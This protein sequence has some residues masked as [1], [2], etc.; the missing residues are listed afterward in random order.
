MPTYSPPGVYVEETG[1]RAKAIEGVPTSVT[2]FVGPTLAVPVKRGEHPRLTSF[3]E[4][5]AIYG[6]LDDLMLGGGGSAPN[7]LAY[8]ARAFF[9]GGG[10]R[11]YVATTP[12]GGSRQDYADALAGLDD[13]KEITLVA[14]P[15]VATDAVTRLLLDHVEAPGRHRFA[16]LDP[17][18][19]ATVAEVQAFRAAYDSRHAALYY[20]WVLATDPRGGAQ[21]ALPPSGFACAAFARTD[22]ERGVWK[23][24]ANEMVTGAVGLERDITKGVQDALHPLG[25]NCI[26][27]LTGRGIRIS[28]ARTISS[29]PE[30]KYVNLRRLM[31]YLEASLEKGLQWAVFEPNAPKLWAQVAQA[32]TDFLYKLWRDGGLMGAKPEEAFFVRC[33]RSTMTGVD[34]DAGR[35]VCL[36]GVAAVRPAEFLIFGVSQNTSDATG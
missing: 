8:A 3:A 34:L 13:L 22:V 12:A 32:A 35:L 29:E 28:G 30:W 27:A 7:D 20:P 10:K 5:A 19:G 31:T 1:F 33:D 14:A 17:P 6:G 2:A 23:A 24:P 4:F 25:V 11:L 18:K 26:R 21:I 16:L 15:G 9:E 36:I